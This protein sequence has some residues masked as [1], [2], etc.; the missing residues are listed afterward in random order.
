VHL[1]AA[2]ELQPAT[3]ANAAV[4]SSLSGRQIS[5]GMRD[6][7]PNL[8][9]VLPRRKFF[10]AGLLSSIALASGALPRAVS[11]AVTKTPG[12][13]FRGLKMGVTSYS[14]RKFSLDEAIE[15]TKKA[16]VKYIS[17][18][19]V[20]LPLN[21]TTEQRK[22]AHQKIADAGL[23]LMGGGVIYLKNE[24]AAIRNAFQYCK[25]AGMATMVCSPE[26]EALNTM[27]QMVKEFDV[28]VAIHNHGPGDKRF[29][30]A[31]D[32]MRLVKG[33]DRRMGACIDV[34]HT[35]R[36]KEDPIEVIKKCADRLY[37]FHM[38][39]VDAAVAEGKPVEVGRGVIDIPG[40]LKTLLKI[41]FNSHVALE[42]EA[43][44]EDPMPGMLESYAFI[45]GALA[46]LP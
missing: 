25:D 7:K 10:Q 15:M 18:K 17:L 45:R 39:D 35:V 36:L 12:D 26:P 20:H 28:R 44:P 30:S 41:K 40:V 1:D 42:Y 23:I 9:D 14:L 11:A 29:P 5:G 43:H 34:G 33:R 38:K 6:V 3:P 8:S 24:P 22:A 2:P 31:L 19:E 21:S 37:E 32:V 13:P 16:G 4:Q 46:G 27:E